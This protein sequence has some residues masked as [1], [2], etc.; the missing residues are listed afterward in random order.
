MTD[1]KTTCILRSTKDYNASNWDSYCLLTAPNGVIA[2]CQQT[3]DDNAGASGITQWDAT[4][5]TE[6]IQQ[7][8][9]K[10]EKIGFA[11]I[12]LE[13]LVKKL[14]RNVFVYG[15]E[16]KEETYRYPVKIEMQK[17]DRGTDL[18][19]QFQENMEVYL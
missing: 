10:L 12:E 17:V 11:N 3:M 8:L 13:T 4:F 7:A 6:L 18:S 15:E 5:P 1:E 9:L 14:A 2:T 19:I 16:K